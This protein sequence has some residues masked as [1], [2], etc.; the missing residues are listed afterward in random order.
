MAKQDAS[1]KE[2]HARLKEEHARALLKNSALATKAE[3]AVLAVKSSPVADR[4]TESESESEVNTLGEKEL[5]E[6]RNDFSEKLSKI[7]KQIGRR[8]DLI[9]SL[10]QRKHHVSIDVK[11][12]VTND[13]TSLDQIRNEVKQIS[14]TTNI[15]KLRT[16]LREIEATLAE[17][18]AVME[19]L[20]KL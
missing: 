11:P 13:G 4:S 7:Q 9:D 19:R 16:K 2:E 10:K 12:L 6:A 15:S 8:K 3:P 5:A 20:S 18:I 17:D 1:L 14:L